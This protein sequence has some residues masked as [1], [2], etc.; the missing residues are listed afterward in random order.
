MHNN[1]KKE[2]CLDKQKVIEKYR[3]SCSNDYVWELKHDKYHTIK[4][5]THR[6]AKKHSALA[7][8]FYINRLCYAKIKY[9]EK[10]IDKY[11]FYKYT[12]EYGFIKCEVCEMDFLLHKASDKMIDL[13]FLKDI[14]SISEFNLFCD[15]LERYEKYVKDELLEKLI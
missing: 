11:D 9:F 5:F 2:L 3:L 7:L 12:F 10:N 1:P 14:K 8:V 4:Y 13:R 6:F 15:K